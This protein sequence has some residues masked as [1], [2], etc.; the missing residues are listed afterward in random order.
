M[1]KLH[2]KFS[3]KQP[4]IKFKSASISFKSATFFKNIKGLPGKYPAILNIKRT[5]RVALI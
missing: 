3:Q 5:G 4:N 2:K 1:S